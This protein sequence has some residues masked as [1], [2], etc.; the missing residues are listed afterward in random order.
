MGEGM[1][2]SSERSSH[3]VHVE[4][5]CIFVRL[6]DVGCVKERPRDLRSGS[7]EVARMAFLVSTVLLL[8]PD[9]VD[10][11]LLLDIPGSAS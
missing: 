6:I 9:R 4:L 2:R 7:F 5:R 10:C 3:A 11:D 1:S 8:Q